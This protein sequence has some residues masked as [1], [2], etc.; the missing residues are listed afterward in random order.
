MSPTRLIIGAAETTNAM[1]APYTPSALV[2][3]DI[4][5]QANDPLVHYSPPI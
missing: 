4:V 2:V 1:Q 5:W 3:Q